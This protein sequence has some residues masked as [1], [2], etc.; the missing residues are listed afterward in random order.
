MTRHYVASFVRRYRP[1]SG[2]ELRLIPAC[3]WR[4]LGLGLNPNDYTD[5]GALATITGGN[6][7]QIQPLLTQIGRIL[8]INALRTI[9]S[10][11]VF[12]AYETLVIGEVL[13]ARSIEMRHIPSGR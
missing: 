1:L 13:L 3:K 2:D 7:R 12:T 11:V 9:S 10:D 4:Q 6:F 5:V 8:T